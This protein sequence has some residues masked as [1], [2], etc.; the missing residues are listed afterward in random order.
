IAKLFIEAQI[1]VVFLITISENADRFAGD[2]CAEVAGKRVEIDAKIG[3]SHTIGFH[4]QFLLGRFEIRIDFD[5]TR[6]LFEFGQDLGEVNLQLM[7]VRSL[8]RDTQAVSATASRTA[9]PGTTA[10]SSWSATTGRGC[11]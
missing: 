4:T 3:G 7:D 10:A 5:E 6:N 2:H 1:D 11:P 9:S 8:N